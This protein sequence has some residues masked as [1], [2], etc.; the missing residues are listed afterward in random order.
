LYGYTEDIEAKFQAIRDKDF[1]RLDEQKCVYLDYTG[2]M[3]AP[4]MLVDEHGKLL[5]ESILG[6]PHS[7]NT[8]SIAST[9]LDEQARQQVLEFCKADPNEYEVIWTAN[10]SGALKVVAECYPFARNSAF[11]YAP[12]CHNSVLGISQFATKKKARFG[13]FQ[14]LDKSLCYDWLS[15][16]QRMNQLTRKSMS[17]APKLFALPGE[18]NSSGLKHNVRRYVDHAHEHGW[19]VCVD[20]AAFAPANAIDMQALGKPEFVSMSFYKIFGYPTGVGC[21]VA[22]RSSLKNFQKPWFAGGTVRFVGVS[23]KD[24]F[25]LMFGSDSHAHYEDGTV[26]FQSFGAIIAG[27]RYMQETVGMHHLSRHVQYWSALLEMRLRNMTWENG[28]PMV[29]IPP[30]M[31]HDEERG[32]ALALVFLTPS[33]LLIP[34]RILEKIISDRGIAVRTGCFCN[35]GT[36]LHILGPY[37]DREGSS[38]ERFVNR[39]IPRM[40]KMGRLHEV[41]ERNPHQGFIRVSFGLATNR[42]DVEAFRTCIEQDVWSK[43]QE[44]EQQTKTFTASC[45]IP[46]SMC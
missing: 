29:F 14:F 33:G 45:A 37:M 7:E 12:D 30:I 44:M 13:G 2:A 43:P 24:C 17:K 23:S 8:P 19:D 18:S 38:L 35:P 10:A 41:I 3:L 21:L 1:A 25:P 40:G 39:Y 36:G 15:F 42:A 28:A 46:Y 20:L 26:N 6:N 16:T 11:L 31:S 9:K 34:H 4:K 32:H 27:I 22:K 5:L